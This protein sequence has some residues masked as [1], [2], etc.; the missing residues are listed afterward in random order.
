M[1]QI[2]FKD[3]TRYYTKCRDCPMLDP[4]EKECPHLRGNDLCTA[5]HDCRAIEDVNKIQDW[6]PLEDAIGDE[7]E[8]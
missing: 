4:G 2:R 3:E 6:C 5:D 7:N 1:K 8:Q